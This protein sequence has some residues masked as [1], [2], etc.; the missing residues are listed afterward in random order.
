MMRLA[1]CILVAA[2]FIGTPAFAADDPWITY[3]SREDR[4]S[5]NL[6][7]Q[8][9][10]EEFVYTSEYNSPWK[11]RRYTVEHEGYVHRMTVVDMST[12]VLTNAIDQFRNVG[13]PG[14]EKRGAMAFEATKLRATGKVLMDTYDQL[15]VIPGH[16]LEI[17]LPDGR[18]NIVALHTHHHLLYIQE[19]ISPKGAVPGYDVQSSMEL[20][21]AMG[22][23][24]R[25]E[26]DGFPGNIPRAAAGAGAGAAGRNIVQEAA[27][28]DWVPMADNAPWGTYVARQDRFVLN[29]PARPRV[30][31]FTYMSAAGSPWKARRYISEHQGYRYVMTVV[32][33]STSRL[34]PGV[35]AFRNTARPGSERAGALAHAAFN[36]R[37]TGKVTADSYEELQVIPGHKLDIELPDGRVNLVEIHQHYDFLYILEC[38]SPKDAVPGYDVQSS[39]ELLDGEGNVPRYQDN[40]RTFPAFV[41]MTGDG[42]AAAG[43]API[44]GGGGRAGGN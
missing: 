43:R 11:A 14:N 23:T 1:R 10:V 3:T 2:I 19:S 44:G 25:Y 4:F 12:T 28:R 31:E 39:L 26:D 27:G 35:D 17:E 24:P 20:H 6:P 40:D 9:R 34:A 15:Q 22:G 42:A 7:G 41:T 32:D 37:K 16:K 33:T 21:D 8:P 13:R 18:Q 29:L 5:L 36:L 38:I 30:E